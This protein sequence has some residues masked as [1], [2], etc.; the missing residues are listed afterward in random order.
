MITTYNNGH[1]D[2]EV[3]IITMEVGNYN[4]SMGISGS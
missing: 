3:I 2:H 1:N 4:R